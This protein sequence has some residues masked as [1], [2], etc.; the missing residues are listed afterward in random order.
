M[1]H[2]KQKSSDITNITKSHTL[3]LPN[4][5]IVLEQQLH[6]YMKVFQNIADQISDLN[7]RAERLQD[8]AE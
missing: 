5:E 8:A 7:L 3:G 1:E 2:L 6:S 4:P